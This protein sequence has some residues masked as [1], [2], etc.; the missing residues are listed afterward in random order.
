[1]VTCLGALVQDRGQ[2]MGVSSIFLPRGS[3]GLNLGG[4]AGWQAP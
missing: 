2:L 1:M 3:V 4:Q